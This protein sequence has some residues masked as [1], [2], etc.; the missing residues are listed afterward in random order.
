MERLVGKASVGEPERPLTGIVSQGHYSFK[1]DRLFFQHAK[2]YGEHKHSGP[3][4][5]R[6]A[7][8]IARATDR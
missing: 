7:G 6:L 3:D 8:G 2:R 4:R 1:F 5:S